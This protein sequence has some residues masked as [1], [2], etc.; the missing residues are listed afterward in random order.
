MH[1]FTLTVGKTV[2]TALTIVEAKAL[3]ARIGGKIEIQFSI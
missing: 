1:Y 3:Q 2:Y